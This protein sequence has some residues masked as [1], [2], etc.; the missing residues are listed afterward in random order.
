M[1]K[2]AS[3]P[4]SRVFA[5]NNKKDKRKEKKKEKKR[6]EKKEKGQNKCSRYSPM[7]GELA[8]YI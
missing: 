3:S 5:N 4:A 7:K 2:D 6:E 8:G 1:L